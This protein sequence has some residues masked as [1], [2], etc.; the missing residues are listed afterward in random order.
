M[1]R[2]HTL[3][4]LTSLLLV[5]FSLL[6]L[7]TSCVGDNG[8]TVTSALITGDTPGTS[9][10]SADTAGTVASSAAQTESAAPQK[11]LTLVSGGASE[12]RIIVPDEAEPG[13]MAYV[14][15]GELRTE[16]ET[17]T[18]YAPAIATDLSKDG[19]YRS[20][21][22]EILLGITDYP[23][24]SD[25]LSGMK[26]GDYTVC[27]DGNKLVVAAYAY[28]AMRLAVNKLI[29]LIKYTSAD[30]TLVI[31]AD[32]DIN[33]VCN[34][35]LN[36]VPI[37]DDGSF[38]TVY[39]C[40]NG[41]MELIIR[42]TTDSEYGSY[43]DKLTADGFTQY[44]T[45]SINDNHFATYNKSGYTVNAGFYNYESSV[46]II[47]AKT[48]PAAGLEAENIYT[49]V[50]TSQITMLGVEYKN[51]SGSYSSMGLSML[52]RLADGRFVII[53]GGFKRTQQATQLVDMIKEQAADYTKPGGKI[54][55]AAWIITHAHS[56]HSGMLS[57]NYASFRQFN[58]ERMLVNF[59]AESE[60]LKAM[61][62]TPANWDPGEGSGYADVIKAAES[63]NCELHWV[64]TGQ[65]FH[66]ANLKTEILYTI[67]SYGP[68]VC[69]AFNTTSLVTKMTFS[70]G[71]VFM[72]TG[73]ATGD[74]L[75]IC[76]QMYAKE[77][78]SDIVLVAHHGYSTWGN[79]VGTISA[80]RYMQP[81]VL[82]W[83]QGF[84]AYPTYKVKAYN[85]VLFSP[86]TKGGTNSNFKECLVSGAEG[87]SVTIS[88][89]YTAGK[90]VTVRK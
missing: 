88:I 15:A 10:I 72:M 80:Y 57:G 29:S 19:T 5:I 24:S 9:A 36:A 33:G 14:C 12:C 70:D 23:Q 69:N 45:N 54:T 81:E 28:A 77:L 3:R 39:E 71:T 62:T 44:V 16:I 40:G 86:A 43:L 18:G 63:L 38:G 66:L 11:D 7:L 58:V 17:R 31:A 76:A 78:K 26:Y 89:P 87:D 13:D 34:T 8:E 2:T 4:Q 53:D 27:V 79:D 37:Y 48:E 56:D 60:R 47:I 41:A 6:S 68:K 30:G 50:T 75:K 20:D 59:M 82:L 46:R 51:S 64:H 42:D 61:D 1:H 25:I 35:L 74:A 49:E 83:S 21:T 32:T 90:A 55:I 65:V 22:V 84:N 67:E 73:D 85:A 52:I